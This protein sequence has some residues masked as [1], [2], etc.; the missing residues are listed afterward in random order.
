M[1]VKA[2][3]YGPIFAPP[4]AAHGDQRHPGGA[5]FFGQHVFLLLREALVGTDPGGPF[6][7]LWPDR[8]PSCPL[9][10]LQITLRSPPTPSPRPSLIFRPP[11][12]SPL[13]SPIPCSSLTLPAPPH[14]NLFSHYSDGAD[15]FSLNSKNH[16]VRAD[17]FF[18]DWN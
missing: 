12:L 7:S 6:H 13:P 4:P 14:S 2:R 9:C 1:S 17:S 10:P 11:A 16:A 18:L 8:F 15:K 3:C 5:G